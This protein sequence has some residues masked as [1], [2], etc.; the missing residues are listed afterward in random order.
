MIV[1]YFHELTL[2]NESNNNNN[3]RVQVN[4]YYVPIYKFP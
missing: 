3:D 1:F 4:N 2:A